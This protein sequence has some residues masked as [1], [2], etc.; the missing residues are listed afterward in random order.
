MGGVGGV[1]HDAVG[2]ARASCKENNQDG[3]ERATDDLCSSVN[4]LL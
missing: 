3:G 2:F 4:C 1:L